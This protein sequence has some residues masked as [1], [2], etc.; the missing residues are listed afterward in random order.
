[1]GGGIAGG[2]RKRRGAEGGEMQVRGPCKPTWKVALGK[3][4]TEVKRSQADMGWKSF[5]GENGLEAG[6]GA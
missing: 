1:M 4:P 3:D 6:V 5:L 2:C